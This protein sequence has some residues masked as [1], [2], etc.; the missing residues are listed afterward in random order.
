MR[1]AFLLRYQELCLADEVS[2]IR[3]GTQT[4]TKVRPEQPDND[5]GIAALITL[6]RSD[7]FTK[8]EIREEPKMPC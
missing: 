4:F 8:L 2:H 1:T 7:I 6:P 5:P 3:Y